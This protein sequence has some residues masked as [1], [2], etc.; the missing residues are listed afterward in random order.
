MRPSTQTSLYPVSILVA[1]WLFTACS[2][3]LARYSHL[4][5]LRVLAIASEPATPAP[6]E[7][8]T[9]SALTFAPAAAPIAYH[10]SWCPVS[11]SASEAYACPF[12]DADT[13]RFFGRVVDPSVASG[14]PKL[15]LGT[16]S[17][18]SFTNPFS[19][20]A[21]SSLCASGLDTP[22]YS[23][24]LDCQ[25]G[26]PIMVVL[27]AAAGAERLRAGFVLRL[28]VG[29]AG[30]GNLNPLPSGL[31]LADQ[32]L[33]DAPT[34]ILV[35]PGETLALRADID[36]QAAETRAIPPSEGGP[37]LRRERLTTSW[38][39]TAGDVDKDRTSF[40]EGETTIADMG[41]NQW[42]APTRELWPA[43]G[44]LQIA[45]VVRDD[46]G[47]MGWMSRQVDLVQ[48]P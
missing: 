30:D 13:A 4:D 23:R 32:P 37:G 29:S 5:R 16:A 47:G 43:D 7:T 48:G 44:K 19:E 28:P 25:D 24:D 41:Q 36:D 42:T 3:D 27:D 6:G 21:L 46:R 18:A 12:D 38:F 40:I 1:A 2:D 33:T 14:L 10:W 31:A 15:D 22:A 39:V 20:A 26:F 35:S 34:S 8:A 11:T 9:L 17:I 45:V